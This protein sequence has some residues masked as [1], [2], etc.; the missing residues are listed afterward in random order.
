M[1]GDPPECKPW[2]INKSKLSKACKE[3]VRKCAAV[4]INERR[5]CKDSL[6]C[7]YM[8][9]NGL[10]NEHTEVLLSGRKTQVVGVGIILCVRSPVS[11]VRCYSNQM[12]PRRAAPGRITPYPTPEVRLRYYWTCAVHEAVVLELY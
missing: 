7:I 9:K 10:E 4:S 1:E 5:W 12:R 11:L 8:V 2:S 3:H 6:A